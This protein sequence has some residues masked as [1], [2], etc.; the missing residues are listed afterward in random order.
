MMINKEGET[1][2]PKIAQHAKS[3]LQMM[4]DFCML[5]MADEPKYQMQTELLENFIDDAIQHVRDIADFKSI[6]IQYSEPEEPVFVNANARLL[7]RAL[8]NLLQNA[9]KFSPSRSVIL[10]LVE[11]MSK[12]VAID[13]INPVGMKKS[14]EKILPGFGLGMHFVET[15]VAKHHANLMLQIPHEGMAKVTLELPIVR[16]Q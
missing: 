3:L 4:D 7:V 14:E 2:N 10:V 1:P 12:K 5:M 9:V 15:V 8:T 16:E 13:I 11:V 6:D